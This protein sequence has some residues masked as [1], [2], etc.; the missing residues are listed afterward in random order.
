VKD[1]ASQVKERIGK[2]L[3]ALPLTLGLD[4]SS[5]FRFFRRGEPRE[6]GRYS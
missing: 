1:Q 5:C 4:E 2:E 3:P 6:R